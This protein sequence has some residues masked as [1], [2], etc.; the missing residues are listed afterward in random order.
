MLRTTGVIR[1]MVFAEIKHHRTQLLES[2]PAY[3]S[4]CRA[5]SKELAGGLTQVQQTVYRAVQELSEKF[6]DKDTE[7]GN[8][9]TDTHLIRPRSF[10]IVGHLSQLLSSG[11]GVI[12]EKQRSFELYRRNLYEPEI[13]TFDE[14]LARAEWL[15]SEAEDQAQ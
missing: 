7:G 9:G 6:A 8:L 14:L 11:G 13:I 15:V 10:L 4:G 3:R 1:S 2:G 5:P 12:D